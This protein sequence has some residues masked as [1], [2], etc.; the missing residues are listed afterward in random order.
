[1]RPIVSEQD[2]LI[3]PLNVLLGTQAQVRLL[4]VM[5]NEVDGPISASDVARLAG[6][7]IPGAQKALG[8]L[9]A[10]GFITRVG[11]GRKHLYEI[12]RSDS[13]MQAVLSLFQAEKVRYEDL[14]S[15]L[16]KTIRECLP[17]P[18][19]AWIKASPKETGEPLTLAVL[20][21]TRYLSDC[22]RQLRVQ[23]KQVE[24][25][26]NLTIE[27]EGY[28]RA[29]IFDPIPGNG[30]MLYGILPS[31]QD[32]LQIQPEKPLTHQEK[33]RRLGILSSKLSKAVEQDTSLLRRARDYVDRL[34]KE[35]QGTANRDIEEWRDILAN[36]STQRLSRFL[37]SSS[38]RAIRLRQ[39]NPFFAILN[40][41]ER[42][43]LVDGF[44]S[45][46][47]T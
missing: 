31:T 44:L 16:K 3:H 5:A 4:R 46:Y 23:L 25:D 38:E 19:A 26:F 33:D 41:D 34:L 45:K 13:L 12:R 28:T 6:L 30:I 14:W 17:H 11:G 37:T 32:P 7:T 39:S 35:D 8:K 22:V 2:P 24:N 27:I 9:I 20:H 1:M 42:A 43:H 21:E 40:D 10:S 29:D 18:H 47:E 15:V 36:Y